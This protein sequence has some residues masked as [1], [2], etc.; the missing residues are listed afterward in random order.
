MAPNLITAQAAVLLSM[1][2]ISTL[3]AN[4]DLPISSVVD[5]NKECSVPSTT[6]THRPKPQPVAIELGGQWIAWSTDGLRIIAYGETLDE[7]ERAAHQTDEQEPS[8]ERTSRPMP[9]SSD[10]AHEVRLR[11]YLVSPS[12]TAPA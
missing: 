4:L 10:A 9:T 6:Q 12:P 3:A 5:L 11:G 2:S 7:C 8:F 1:M